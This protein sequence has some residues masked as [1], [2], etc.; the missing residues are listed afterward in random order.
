MSK[1]KHGPALLDLANVLA[2]EAS[3]HAPGVSPF[4]AMDYAIGIVNSAR[5]QHVMG[6][7][8]SPERIR[9]AAAALLVAS[10]LI[11]DSAA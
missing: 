4:A 7:D 11:E 10:A 1:T 6:D 2:A 9:G 5:M 8:I 3:A